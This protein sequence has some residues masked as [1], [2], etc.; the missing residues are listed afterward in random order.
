MESKVRRYII[1]FIIGLV[2][3]SGCSNP[4]NEK[5]NNTVTVFNEQSKNV[6]DNEDNNISNTPEIMKKIVLKVQNKT[7]RI[8][9]KL[10]M[11]N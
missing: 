7:R 11:Q 1:I 2:F 5:E 6:V 10:I 3:V 9:L 4:K 8:N